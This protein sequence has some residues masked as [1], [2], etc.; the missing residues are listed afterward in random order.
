MELLK[1]CSPNLRI[2]ILLIHAVVCCILHRVT[3]VLQPEA[4][5]LN[6]H[7]AEGTQMQAQLVTSKIGDNK[8]PTISTKLN[9]MSHV[10]VPLSRICMHISQHPRLAE[11]ITMQ[12]S[13][14]LFAVW[15]KTGP[16]TERLTFSHGSIATM[17]KI[18]RL[19]YGKA[20][21]GKTPWA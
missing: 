1:E 21:Q 17:W 13:N 16:P 3:W 20:G 8:W 6:Q 4:E 18:H 12:A 5:K 10:K 9:N 19:H 15:C 14:W 11:H 7:C 2:D